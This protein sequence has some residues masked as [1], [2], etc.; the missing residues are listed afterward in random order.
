MPVGPLSE[1][2]KQRVTSELFSQINGGI[3]IATAIRVGQ[4]LGA[5]RFDA[6]KTVAHL[7]VAFAGESWSSLLV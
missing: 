5:G 1:L 7:A 4:Q 3:Q 2:I 6:A